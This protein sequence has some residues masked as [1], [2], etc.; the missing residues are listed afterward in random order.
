MNKKLKTVQIV[1]IILAIVFGT[2]LH[3]TYEWSGENRIVGLFSATNESVWEHLKLVFY[4]MLILAIVEYFVVKKEAN[5]YIEAKSLGIFLAIAFIIVFYYTYTGIIG[6][7]FFII[8]IL[9]FIISIIL[10]EWVSYKLMIRKS[11]STTLSKI[12]SSA[13]IFYFL[14]SFILFTYNPPNINLFKDPTQI[15][16]RLYM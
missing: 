5:N 11:E 4:P 1:V 13:I 9:T 7:T 10:G 16:N 15:M 3:F 8:D 6:K 14:I 2:L 12:L